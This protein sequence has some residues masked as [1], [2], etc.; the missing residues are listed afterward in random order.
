MIGSTGGEGIGNSI[1]VSFTVGEPVIE[2]GYGNSI[3]ATQGFQQPYRTTGDLDVTV[4][5]IPERC[6]GSADGSA[7][8]TTEGC[9][10]PYTYNW[11]H[12]ATEAQATGLSAGNYEV[13]I[14]SADGCETTLIVEITLED[15]TP[16]GL[17]FYSGITPNNDGRNDYWII[18]NID[19]FQPNSVK[20]FNRWGVEVWAA[21]NYDNVDVVWDG[22]NSRGEHL[23]DATYFYLVEIEDEV[24]KGYVE[25]TR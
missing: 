22:R 20:I 23:P 13:T 2:T 3:I 10:A 16:C 24:Y 4:E 8:L 14:T 12:G 17:K 18:D 1:Q 11:S 9:A 7:T 19:L 6:D 21:E 5:T 25:I 15:E